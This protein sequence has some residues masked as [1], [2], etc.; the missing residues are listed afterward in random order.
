MSL[1]APLPTKAILADSVADKLVLARAGLGGGWLVGLEVM[2]A[3]W[4]KVSNAALP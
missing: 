1:D 3:G 4:G 2:K